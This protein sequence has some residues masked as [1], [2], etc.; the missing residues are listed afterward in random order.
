MQT[1]LHEAQNVFDVNAKRVRLTYKVRSVQMLHENGCKN[2]CMPH[3]FHGYV[4]CQ[5]G[6]VYCAMQNIL[7]KRGQPHYLYLMSYMPCIYSRVFY[8]S[9]Q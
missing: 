5:Q 7:G 2:V 4:R 9:G 6:L 8:D 3:I 1:C